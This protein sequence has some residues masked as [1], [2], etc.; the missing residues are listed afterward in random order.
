MKRLHYILVILLSLTIVY[1]G[2][3]VSIVHYCCARCETA[4]ACCTDGCAKCH[5]S[6]KS[7]KCHKFSHQPEK[8]CKYEGCTATFYK[9]DLMRYSNESPV[10]TVP[11]IQLLCEALPDFL[12]SLPAGELKE[13]AYFIPPH[14]DSSRQY[15]ALYS[16]LII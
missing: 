11:V 7:P 2:A 9:V 13:A 10:I 4:Q 15:L 6:H 12:Y 14:P 3:G 1:A 5:K 8:F 16:V